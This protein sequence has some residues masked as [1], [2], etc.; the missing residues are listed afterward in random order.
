MATIETS[1]PTGNIDS[2]ME[3]KQRK[4]KHDEIQH[5]ALQF[6]KLAPGFTIPK[7]KILK[8]KRMT[9]AAMNMLYKSL[10]GNKYSLEDQEKRCERGDKWYNTLEAN[11]SIT[12]EPWDKTIK[13]SENLEIKRAAQNAAREERGIQINESL[14]KISDIQTPA[15]KE[16]NVFYYNVLHE[17]K[18]EL[19]KDCKP[20]ERLGENAEQRPMFNRLK[21]PPLY[22]LLH[23]F[24]YEWLTRQHRDPTYWQECSDKLWE[25][26]D[27]INNVLLHFWLLIQWEH[28]TAFLDK[29]LEDSIKIQLKK[30]KKRCR[31]IELP[32]VYLVDRE[33][34][35]AADT[36][37]DSINTWST[38]RKLIHHTPFD[39]S[40]PLQYMCFIGE[41]VKELI[42][43]TNADES[44]ARSID[45]TLEFFAD[46]ELNIRTTLIL[47]ES[48]NKN[49]QLKM[50]TQFHN[51]AETYGTGFYKWNG[52]A[53]ELKKIKEKSEETKTTQQKKKVIVRKQNFDPL[54]NPPCMLHRKGKTPPS[55]KPEKS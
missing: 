30:C 29:Y 16:Q 3:N 27:D 20:D 28:T 19:H 34:I 41:K 7:R 48:S 24:V 45:R 10:G 39:G 42:I 33:I 52:S 5:K 22:C 4:R 46:M 15:P 6:P 44:I 53:K 32:P 47:A 43:I 17:C 8:P 26:K 37:L 54:R 25:I 11:V 2:T 1:K 12:T 21:I 23:V 14:Q 18:G 13:I 49:K 40:K 55:R 35:V 50:A 38:D 36:S 31:E 51:L 9:I